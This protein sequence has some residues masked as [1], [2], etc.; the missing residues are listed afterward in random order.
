MTPPLKHCHFYYWCH[1][2]NHIR[3]KR[4]RF[5]INILAL[6]LLSAGSVVAPLISNVWVLAALSWSSMIVKG[7]LEFCK[8]DT[9]VAM[10]RVA[11]TSY[12]KC[13][14]NLNRNELIWTHHM[15]IDLAPLIPDRIQRRYFGQPQ[16]DY[17][18]GIKATDSAIPP[19][20]QLRPWPPV[21]VVD[22]DDN[23][24]EGYD[25]TPSDT[26]SLTT[27]IRWSLPS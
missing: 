20:L 12:A 19:I 10:S 8:Y 1:R 9:K 4:I 23:N 17:L 27:T 26:S 15:M 24:S 11:Y 3:L 7:F 5:V 6:I 2:Q 18:D 16:T 13:L 22:D 25:T 21:N 14:T